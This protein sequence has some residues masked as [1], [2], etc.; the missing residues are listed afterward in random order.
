MS[1]PRRFRVAL[2][3]AGIGRDHAL[4]FARLPELFELAVVVD[5]DRARA[6]K[7]AKEVAAAAVG[8]D[9]DAVLGRDDIDIVDVCTPPFLHALMAT[10]A[11]RAGK[12]VI[13][14]KPLAGS[15][16]EVDALIA[17][18]RS[19][20]RRFLPVFQYRFGNG[21]RKLAHLVRDGVAGRAFVTTIETHWNRGPGYYGTSWRGRRSSELGGAVVSHAIHAN[22]LACE[23]HGNPTRVFARTAI[24]VNPVET[25]DCA[26]LAL[27]MADGAL[28][29][30]SI[31]LGAANEIS[32]LRFCFE[33]LTAESQLAPYAPASEPWQ[34]IPRGGEAAKGKLEAALT[35][36]EPG[37]EGFTGLME[38]FHQALTGRGPLPVSLRDARRS[39]E[40]ASAIYQSAATG[41]DV[42]LPIADDHLAYRGWAQASS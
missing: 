24:R 33:H 9:F 2:I 21:Y 40:L 34:F 27:Q 38:A 4:A 31:T 17:L 42:G 13:C 35:G 20:G 25:E 32:R 41:A 23:V 14:E 29:T 16:A 36:F 22:D 10:A 30:H 28:L 18:E 19:S 15:L 39:I 3:G 5:L 6:E 12:H 11:L 26:T 1:A 37:T 8:A 7:L